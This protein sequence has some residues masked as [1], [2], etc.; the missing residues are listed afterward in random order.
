M[1]EFLASLDAEGPSGKRKRSQKYFIAEFQAETKV[2]VT[3]LRR[4][5]MVAIRYSKGYILTFQEILITSGACACLYKVALQVL[6]C[7]MFTD[8]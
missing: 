8:K 6:C 2:D 7:F 3:G 5:K 1:V 4:N